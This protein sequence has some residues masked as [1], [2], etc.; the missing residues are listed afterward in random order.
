MIK[1]KLSASERGC[2]RNTY[3]GLTLFHLHTVISTGV[4]ENA[5]PV[6]P[7]G[8]GVAVRTW[9]TAQEFSPTYSPP[10]AREKHGQQGA[11][12]A[13]AWWSSAR[14]ACENRARRRTAQNKW[15]REEQKEENS[16]CKIVKS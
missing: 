5:Y 16:A 13:A 14:R 9:T 4:Y 15:A 2:C 3:W 1:K 7:V 10:G 8:G 6:L 12:R 11:A